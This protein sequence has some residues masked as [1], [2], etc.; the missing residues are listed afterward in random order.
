MTNSKVI[1][2]SKQL[3]NEFLSHQRLLDQLEID[4]VYHKMTTNKLNKIFHETGELSTEF[5][6]RRTNEKLD[7]DKTGRY[8]IIPDRTSNLFK[9]NVKNKVDDL[10]RIVEY[11]CEKF[12]IIEEIQELLKTD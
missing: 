5:L 3:K 1:L 11:I 12:G 6:I 8:K 2:S 7:G 4:P 10:V 9:K